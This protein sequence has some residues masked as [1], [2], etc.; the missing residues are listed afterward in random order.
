MEM[1]IVTSIHTYIHCHIVSWYCRDG[2]NYTLAILKSQ[3]YD[4]HKGDVITFASAT[5]QPI[6]LSLAEDNLITAKK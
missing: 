6:F 4:R 3:A 2:R 1:D 5:L